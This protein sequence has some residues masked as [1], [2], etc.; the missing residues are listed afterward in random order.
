[1]QWDETGA[2]NPA[3][4]YIAARLKAQIADA[5]QPGGTVPQPPHRRAEQARRSRAEGGVH[6]GRRQRSP[7]RC[8][9]QASANVGSALL[10]K[11]D[12]AS[13]YEGTLHVSRSGRR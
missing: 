7:V 1:M 10:A 2:E 8:S 3:R 5:L 9:P 4:S 6:E 13:T 12:Q 11:D